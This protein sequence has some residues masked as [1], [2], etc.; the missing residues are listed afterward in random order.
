MRHKW[1]TSSIQSLIVSVI[2]LMI[3]QTVA[4][5]SRRISGVVVFLQFYFRR[6]G[7]PFED[8]CHFT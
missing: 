8:G 2:A 5:A 4:Q 6:K 3:P 1:P 7:K